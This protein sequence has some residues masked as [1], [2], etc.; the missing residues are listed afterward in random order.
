M[1]TR[2]IGTARRNKARLWIE[3][4]LLQDNGFTK[5]V[6]WTVEPWEVQG[7]RTGTRKALALILD[8]DG[9]RT[10]SGTPTRPIID[11]VGKL[12]ADNLACN[13]VEIKVMSR[14][15]LLVTQLD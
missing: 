5:G 7:N 13:T 2:K 10:V 3:G 14:G 1:I 15:R 11:I 12:I 6:K 8:V 9:K 4:S